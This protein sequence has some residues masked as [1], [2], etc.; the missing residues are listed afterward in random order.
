MER[1][2]KI[3]LHKSFLDTY[4]RGKN[5]DESFYLGHM[6]VLIIKK[7]IHVKILCKL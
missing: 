6:V 3:T 5:E 4:I 7:K 1:K 2:I